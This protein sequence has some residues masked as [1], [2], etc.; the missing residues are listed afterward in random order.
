MKVDLL[1]II[2]TREDGQGYEEV[3]YHVT[4]EFQYDTTN[5]SGDAS[6]E[7]LNIMAF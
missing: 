4:L 5:L 1:T 7:S 2:P 6:F 3:A